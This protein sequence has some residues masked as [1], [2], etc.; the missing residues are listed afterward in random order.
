MG[1]EK[2]KRKVF[3]MHAQRTTQSSSTSGTKQK[4]ITKKRKNFYSLKLSTMD[5]N[6]KTFLNFPRKLLVKKLHSKHRDVCT[7]IDFFLTS[8]NPFSHSKQITFYLIK[9]Y[10]LMQQLKSA[11][12]I[13]CLK[14]PKGF[15]NQ[16]F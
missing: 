10:Q 15:L 16:I 8:Q 1:A 2:G 13:S 14:S 3:G 6:A 11:N 12:I 5:D 7:C 4:L 9:I